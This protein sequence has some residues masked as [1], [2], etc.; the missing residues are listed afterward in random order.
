MFDLL[1]MVLSLALV[2]T[3][4]YLNKLEMGDDY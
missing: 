3:A 1:F 2:S 4:M